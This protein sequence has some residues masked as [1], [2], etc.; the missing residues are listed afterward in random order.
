MDQAAAPQLATLARRQPTLDTRATLAH[1]L[2]AAI[3][4]HAAR[5]LADPDW[6]ALATVLADAEAGGHQPASLLKEAAEQR[7]L[8][9]ARKPARVLIARIQHTA[10]DPA[11]N[12][13]A[14]AALMRTANSSTAHQP[15]KT[16]PTPPHAKLPNEHQRRHR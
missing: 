3:P 12:L 16:P 4:D 9:T 8:H 6:P 15:A 14:E 1:D 2:R 5:I 10:R 7:E 11:P 13:R